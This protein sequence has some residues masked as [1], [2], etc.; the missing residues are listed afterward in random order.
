MMRIEKYIKIS[1]YAIC[2]QLRPHVKT[3]P[4]YLRDFVLM[5]P[6]V[7]SRHAFETETEVQS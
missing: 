1:I 7:P 3:D 5:L 6:Q 4:Q 2:I